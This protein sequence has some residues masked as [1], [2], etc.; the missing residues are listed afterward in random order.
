MNRD[1]RKARDRDFALR[2]R[3]RIVWDSLRFGAAIRVGDHYERKP[4][5]KKH[6]HALTEA[7]DN[8]IGRVLRRRQ[9]RLSRP[10]QPYGKR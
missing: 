4:L 1:E 5:V 2:L 7:E 10:W 6:K 3:P 9:N 8:A